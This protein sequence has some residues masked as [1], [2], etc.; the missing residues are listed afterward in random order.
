MQPNYKIATEGHPP[1][2]AHSWGEFMNIGFRACK[3]KWILMI[4]D[5]L[6]LSRGCIEKGFE[7]L[8][9]LQREGKRVGA[10]ALFYRDYPRELRYNVKLLPGDVVLV[11]HGFFSKEAL[12]DIHYIDERSFEFYYADT[13]LCMRLA[14][15]GYDNVPLEGCLAEHLAHMPNYRSLFGKPKPK[16]VTDF[17]TLERR[18]GK[19]PSTGSLLYSDCQPAD[20]SYRQLWRLAPIQCAVAAALRNLGRFRKHGQTSS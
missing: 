6:I 18:W 11:N 9:Q 3:G 2:L 14:K 17:A 13:D 4:S 12:E 15:A 19:F 8:E 7:M 16:G 1:L 10:G 20:R 5:D